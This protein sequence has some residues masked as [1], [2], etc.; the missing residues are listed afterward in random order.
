MAAVTTAPL[1]EILLRRKI[2]NMD[3]LEI[4]FMFKNYFISSLKTARLEC[5]SE[6]N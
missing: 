2:Q 6:M 4:H 1:R 5:M 3:L